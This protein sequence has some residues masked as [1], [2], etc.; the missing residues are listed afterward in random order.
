MSNG[1]Q[2]NARVASSIFDDKRQRDRTIACNGVGGRTDFE[3][4]VARADTLMR[5]VIW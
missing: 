4:N 2:V 3:I 5:T 1:D